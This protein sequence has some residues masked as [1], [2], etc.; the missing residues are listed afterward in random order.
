LLISLCLMAGSLVG[1]VNKKNLVDHK[2]PS[3]DNM[4]TRP[5]ALFGPTNL[6]QEMIY[7]ANRGAG[8]AVQLTRTIDSNGK[9]IQTFEGMSQSTMSWTRDGSLLLH[10]E[11]DRQT[12]THIVYDPPII[13]LPA[14]LSDAPAQTELDAASKPQGTWRESSM[15]VYNLGTNVKR[16]GGTCRYLVQIIGS[17]TFTHG[18]Q[19]RRAAVVRTVRELNLGM[20]QGKV[21]TTTAFIPNVG[22]AYQT[23]EQRLTSMGFIPIRKDERFTWPQVSANTGK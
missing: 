14:S 17:E 1:C 18:H 10:E 8:K 12:N 11:I 3:A 22:I 16:D 7:E 2:L 5:R 4:S 19:T 6:R 9:I 15:T 21:T 23:I 20:A 13:M